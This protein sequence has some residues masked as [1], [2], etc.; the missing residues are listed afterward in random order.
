MRT[1]PA[2]THPH[3]PH[4]IRSFSTLLPS[5]CSHYTCSSLTTELPGRKPSLA[6]PEQ[7]RGK[8]DD[9]LDQ[10][11]S[12][13]LFSSQGWGKWD[14]T[15]RFCMGIALQKTYLSFSTSSRSLVSLGRRSIVADD[16]VSVVI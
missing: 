3:H 8:L 4:R 16:E 1:S 5:C 15:V 12:A 10:E 7:K 14:S 9:Q 11:V 6:R 2:E 13:S